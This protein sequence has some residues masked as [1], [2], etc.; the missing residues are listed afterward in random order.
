MQANTIKKL[1]NVDANPKTVKNH[2]HGY[3]TAVLYLAPA[4]LAS[5]PE[6]PINVCPM[7]ELAQCKDPCL[8]LAGRGV[9]DAT[10]QAR[11]R[12]TKQFFEDRQG[13]M[14]QLAKE[15]TALERRAEK[16]GLKPLVRLNGTSDIKWENVQIKTD[17]TP[18]TIFQLF[19]DV[20]FYDYTK[21]PNRTQAAGFP[22]NYDLTFSHS[23]VPAFQKHTNRAIFYGMRVAVVFESKSLVQDK[24][25]SGFLNL[26]VV[27]GDDTDV[28]HIDPQESVVA[29]YAK[30][31][32][33]R[34]MSG[35]VIRS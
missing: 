12:K 3:L 13:F 21:L 16:L 28:R 6:R 35:F 34:D 15:I 11:I 8:N 4:D 17:T 18:T 23:G 24:M 1:L 30:G 20:Q 32:A 27:D 2:K 14:L 5:T 25:R 31:R 29:L 33:K 10:Q 22:K 7:A 9:F 19:P 26:P